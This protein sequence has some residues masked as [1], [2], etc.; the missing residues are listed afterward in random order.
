[1]KDAKIS[2]VMV[3]P[4][5]SAKTRTSA[6]N[7]ASVLLYSHYTGMPVVD[8]A[9]KVVGMVTELDLLDALMAGKNLSKVSAEE[10]MSITPITADADTPVSEVVATMKRENIIRLPITQKGKLVGIVARCDIL[11]SQMDPTAL[12][13]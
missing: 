2:T 8:D 13:V 1:M 3:Q 7:I 6:E 12:I 9:G 10:I 5:V 4:V 11:K